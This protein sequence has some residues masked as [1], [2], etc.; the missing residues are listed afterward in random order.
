MAAL[1][2]DSGQINLFYYV[3]VFTVIAALPSFDIVF[4]SSQGGPGYSTTVPGVQIYQLGF[5]ESRVGLASALAV[6]LTA[7][8]LVVIVPLQR[9]FREK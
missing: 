9:I 1:L 3:F 7:L 2:K 6:V 8:I 5:T 4:M